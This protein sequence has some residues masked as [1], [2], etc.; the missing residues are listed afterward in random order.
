MPLL[1]ETIEDRLR[2]RIGDLVM[3][4]ESLLVQLDRANAIIEDLKAKIEDNI[5]NE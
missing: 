3:Q 1:V 5:K 4:N 2:L